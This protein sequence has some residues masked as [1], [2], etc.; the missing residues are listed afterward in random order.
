[1]GYVEAGEITFAIEG[2]PTATLRP[3]DVFHEPAGVVIAAFDNAS[4]KPIT[5]VDT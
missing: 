4:T 2:Q 3:G 5:L 1:V